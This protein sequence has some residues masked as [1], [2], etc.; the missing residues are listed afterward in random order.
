M[1]LIVK[2]KRF[3]KILAANIFSSIGSGI[4]MIAI[5][6]M[7]V[8]R[9]NGASTL[10]YVILL[11]TIILFLIAPFI[12]NLVDQLSRKKLLLC[13]EM[14]GFIIISLFV[15]VGFINGSYT[16]W[17][18]VILFSSGMLYDSVFYPTLFA[19]NQE[20]FDRSQYKVLN[21]MME[22]QGQLS[23]VVA[24]GIASIL[25]GK[26]ELHWI[27]IMD[28]ITYAVA[29][30][31]LST[32]PYIKTKYP[33]HEMIDTSFRKKMREGYDYL[34]ERPFLFLLLFSAFTPYIVIM[35]TN[36]VFPIYIEATLQADGSIYGIHEMLYG[37][38]ALLAG[39]I[40]PVLI[41]RFGNIKILL[42]GIL[43]F[44][45]SMILTAIFPVIILFLILSIIFGLGHAITRITRN[46]LMMEIIP[47]DKM[48]R[49]ESLFR[50]IGL[51]IQIT[52]LGIFTVMI[53]KI[54]TI[55][56]VS[57]LS[58]ILIVSVVTAFIGKQYFSRDLMKKY[59]TR[60]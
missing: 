29:F 12:G 4:T 36:Y 40:I 31:I 5:P 50:S 60:K 24:G 6:W 3:I 21:G 49:V 53:P 2:D 48:G 54:G 35:I 9:E 11:L 10:G 41:Q 23:A 20:I 55:P 38:G 13:S 33:S 37:I 52:F 42:A 30:L 34:K 58:L 32:I 43:M 19:M 47:N 59:S 18:L 25:I 7:I 1:S 57:I 22:I 8:T 46:I 26:I 45:L 51:A 15:I 14:I 44:T 28:A 17:H 39:M 27:L 56:A 16:T